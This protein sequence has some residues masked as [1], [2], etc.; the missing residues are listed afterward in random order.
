MRAKKSLGQHFL[1]DMDIVQR[2]VGCADITA[3][4]IVL[5][6]G[7]G[8][9]ILTKALAT[10]AGKVIAL[11]IDDRLCNGLKKISS[12]YN[13]IKFVHTDVLSF[14]YNE[15]KGRFKVIANLPYYIS[16]PI[17]FNLLKN[18]TNVISMVLMLQKEVAER[19]VSLPNK[20][21]YGL[22]SIAV[23]FYSNPEILFCVDK[24]HFSPM[25]DVDSAVV[26]IVPKTMPDIRVK[27]EGFFF[28]VVKASFAHRRK[29][30]INSLIN[31]GYPPEI[32]R[33]G[34]TACNIDLKRRPETLTIEEFGC[35]SDFLFELNL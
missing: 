8:T 17:I 31:R 35:L 11:E 18:D 25:P 32:I 7:A 29:F 20:K 33:K 15:I 1:R 6:I 28:T 16:T 22:L 14:D 3:E 9:G 30:L 26:R 5:E 23:Q 27:D 13:N 10:K 34:L 12:C 4:D 19:I 24:S 2:I 21:S